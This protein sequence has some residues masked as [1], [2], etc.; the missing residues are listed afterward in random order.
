MFVATLCPGPYL[1]DRMR[2]IVDRVKRGLDVKPEKKIL[3]KVQLG[4]FSKKTNADNFAKEVK[5]KGFDVFVT[6]IGRYYKVQ[7]G[8]FSKKANAEALQKKAIAAGYKDAFIVEVKE[9]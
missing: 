2:D 1:H 4:A 6:K 9:D 8:A 3:Y 7:I 5:S